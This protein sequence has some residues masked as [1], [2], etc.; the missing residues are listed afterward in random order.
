MAALSARQVE[1]PM[2]YTQEPTIGVNDIKQLRKTYIRTIPPTT[3]IES[4]KRPAGHTNTYMDTR[5]Q[6]H[7]HTHTNRRARAHYNNYPYV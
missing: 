5:E 2:L 3:P 4:G 7:T 1:G 6:T